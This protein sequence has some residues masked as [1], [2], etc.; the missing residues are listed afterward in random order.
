MSPTA[1]T[2]RLAGLAAALWLCCLLVPAAAGGQAELFVRDVAGDNTR[3]FTIRVTTRRNSPTVSV[4]VDFPPNL[5][6]SGF[7]GPPTDWGLQEITPDDGSERIAGMF[8]RGGEIELGEFTDFQ[9][10]ARVGGPGGIWRVEQTYKDR[11][12][13][14]W[15]G[16]AT[17]ATDRGS[18]PPPVVDPG[19]PVAPAGDPVSAPIAAETGDG[20]N[21]FL[22]WLG[23]FLIAA[24]VAA[25]V[26]AAYVWSNQPGRGGLDETA[27]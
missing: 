15:E 10:I 3:E 1:P 20:R 8:V 17:L 26:A 7:P 6:P 18:A 19:A 5:Q 22:F 4:R 13:E 27:T 16:G 21:G 25:L 9:V 23:I 2:L 11:V 14:V 24:A 12:T